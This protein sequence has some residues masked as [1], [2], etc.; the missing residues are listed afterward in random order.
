[1][2]EHF[3]I[4]FI[5]DN[6]VKSEPAIMCLKKL[7]LVNRIRHIDEGLQQIKSDE[8]RKVIPVVVLPSSKEEKDVIESYKFGVNSYLDNPINFESFG[9]AIT[10]RSFDQ[11]IL[12]QNTNP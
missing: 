4:F 2:H 5:E 3:D 7:R 1:M 9:K 12:N 10:E 8:T 11:M 6:P